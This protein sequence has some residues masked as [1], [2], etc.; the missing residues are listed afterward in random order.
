MFSDL[1]FLS[2]IATHGY[3]HVNYFNGSKLQEHYNDFFGKALQVTDVNVLSLA[4]H[5]QALVVDYISNRLVQQRA[6]EWFCQ[7]WTGPCGRWTLVQAGHAGSN[8]NM[9]VEVDWR[10]MKRLVPQ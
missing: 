6:A 2:G 10:D 9:G 4:S 3:H 5:V 7:W 1:L 8:N